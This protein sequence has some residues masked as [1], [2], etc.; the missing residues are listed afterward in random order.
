MTGYFHGPFLETSAEDYFENL[1]A[2]NWTMHYFNYELI[3]GDFCQWWDY[4]IKLRMFEP[5]F[6]QYFFSFKHVESSSKI[7]ESKQD[8]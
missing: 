7:E 8:S 3:L 4:Q 2:Q 5:I 6:H 1:S